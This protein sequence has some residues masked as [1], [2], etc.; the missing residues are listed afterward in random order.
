MLCWTGRRFAMIPGWLSDILLKISVLRVFIFLSKSS[1]EATCSKALR[2]WDIY[3]SRKM[4][5]SNTFSVPIIHFLTLET[6][7]CVMYLSWVQNDLVHLSIEAFSVNRPTQQRQSAAAFDKLWPKQLKAVLHSRTDHWL[8][9]RSFFNRIVRLLS[10]D[11][12]YMLDGNNKSTTAKL[13][14]AL[15]TSQA[16]YIQIYYDVGIYFHVDLKDGPQCLVKH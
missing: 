11:L 1:H 3:I 2:Q 15:E 5:E 14:P 13:W 16:Y 6:D 7:Q 10:A 12:W 4:A 9:I 8:N